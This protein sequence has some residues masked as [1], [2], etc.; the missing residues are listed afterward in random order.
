[1]EKLFFCSAIWEKHLFIYLLIVWLFVYL[2]YLFNFYVFYL[3]SYFFTYFIYLGI[4]YN[5]YFL[6]IPWVER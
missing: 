4:F 1:M 6:A 3:F 5:H 2:F